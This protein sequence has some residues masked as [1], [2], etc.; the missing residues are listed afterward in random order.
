MDQKE[1]IEKITSEV[2]SKLQD[3]ILSSGAPASV[4]VCTEDSCTN[5]QLCVTI[6]PIGV[7]NILNSGAD[8]VSATVGVVNVPADLASYIDHTLLKPE[9]VKSQFEQLCEEAA[10]YGFYSVCVNSYWADF[11]SRR[12]RGSDVKVCCVVGFPLGAVDSRTK[13]F[14]T[15][16]AIENGASEIDMVINIGALKSGDLNEVEEDIRHVIRACRST[17]VTKV[18]LETCL[19]TD[20]EKVLACEISKKAGADFV[21]TSTGFSKAGATV[22][23]IALL[24]R[25]IGPEMGVKAAGGV[26]TFDDAK[27]MIESGATRIGASASIKIVTQ[28]TSF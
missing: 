13:G 24:R 4:T 21:K 22:Q 15:R 6:N 3:N 10:K 19:L 7:K 12:L 23:D 1:L 28:S 5:C 14:E 20:D 26:R 25:V 18:I 11:C 8:R 9:A 27:L 16:N 2:M 17:T